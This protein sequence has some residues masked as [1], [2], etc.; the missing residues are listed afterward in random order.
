[1]TLPVSWEVLA[2][3]CVTELA[4]SASPG[5]AVFLVVSRAIRDGMP[6]AAAA[7]LGVLVGN[8]VYFA[9]SATA[10]GAVLFALRE[11]FFV[12]QWGG[13]AYLAWLAAKSFRGERETAQRDAPRLAAKN[14]FRESFLVQLANP[15]TIIFFIAFLPLFLNPE[16]PAAGQKRR[17]GAKV[18]AEG[19]FPRQRRFAL[20][21]RRLA[22][23]DFAVNRKGVSENESFNWCSSA[24]LDRRSG[25]Q[26]P[27]G[28]GWW[29]CGCWTILWSAMRS[30]HCASATAACSSRPRRPCPSPPPLWRCAPGRGGRR[31]APC[32]AQ[33]SRA[34]RAR[35]PARQRFS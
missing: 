31:G 33:C 6:S 18:R 1:M 13:A 12:A 25:V 21:R 8:L 24:L 3:F 29:M 34:G 26:P 22:A 28:S 10:V 11:W 15:K 23:F 2:L 14:A 20:R 30:C 4:F 5:P 17:G 27:T 9:V 7:A 35:P 16:K 19:A 32:N